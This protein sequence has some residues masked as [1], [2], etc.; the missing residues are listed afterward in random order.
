MVLTYDAYNETMELQTQRE[1]RIDELE[2]EL[3]ELRDMRQ[4]YEATI[5][6][7]IP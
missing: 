1:D 5:L 4:W 6:G 2:K 3:D 7:I